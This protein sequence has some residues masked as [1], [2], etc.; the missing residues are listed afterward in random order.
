[1]T[2]RSALEWEMSRSGQSATFSRPTAAAAL[3][4]RARPQILS[5]TTGLRLCGIA[6]E[7][8][9]PLANGSCTPCPSVRARARRAVAGEPEGPAGELDAERDRLGV[10]AVRAPDHRGVAVLLGTPDHHLE[11]AV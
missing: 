6:E 4:T 11:C 2:A 10:N 3:T 9:C 5:A 1:M 7:P 8:F